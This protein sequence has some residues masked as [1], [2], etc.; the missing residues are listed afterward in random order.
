M[1]LAEYGR[2]M[3][4]GWWIVAVCMLAGLAAAAAV[5]VTATPVYQSNLKFFVVSP[6]AAGQS[7]LQ[8]RE[9]SKGRIVAYPALVKS[10]KFIEGLVRGSSADL[11]ADAV[12]ES[13]SASAD[14]DT[15]ILS[16]VVSRPD[17][18]QAVDIARRIAGS[19]GDWVGALEAGQTELNLVVGPTE[20][21]DPVSPRAPLNLALGG[22]LGFGAGTA[23]A[24][25]RR[26]RDKT[27]RRAEEV[28]AATGLPLLAVLPAKA[29]TLPA[30]ATAAATGAPAPEPAGPGAGKAARRER[31][32]FLLGEAG[33]RLRTNV[34]HF[35]AMPASGVVTITSATSGEGKSSAAL[36]LARSWAEAGFSVLL[37]E[38][39]LR[40][41]RLAAELGLG[42]RL[43]LAD[44]LAGRVA[45][46]KAIQH[47]EGPGPHILA[48][49]TV[50]AKP[51]EQIGRAHV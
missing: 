33:R 26:L 5:T 6:T 9:L 1:D 35:R 7:P 43:G 49:G 21:T 42:S 30:T 11:P 13:I 40:A 37:V 2:A 31:A 41:P 29:G 38:G 45:V 48:A 34:D 22:V 19:L 17:Q 18:V 24:V 47:P 16:V 50:P 39:D 36:L 25:S 20:E 15:L 32:A 46:A 4:R 8:A 10:D 44:V 3:V 23:I 14:R 27:L 28:E 51:T 12:A